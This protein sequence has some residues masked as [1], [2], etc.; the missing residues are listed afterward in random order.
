MASVSWQTVND[1]LE[2]LS[3]MPLRSA[4]WDLRPT[5]KMFIY[6]EFRAE[7]VTFPRGGLGNN[8]LPQIFSGAHTLTQPL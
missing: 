1:N 5:R 4:A 2:P 3:G 6:K 7:Q 8:L